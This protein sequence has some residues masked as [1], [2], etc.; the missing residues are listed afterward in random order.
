MSMAGGWRRDINVF[1]ANYR[2]DQT[3]SEIMAS[4]PWCN[5]YRDGPAFRGALKQLVG[6]GD[7]KRRTLSKAERIAR[8]ANYVYEAAR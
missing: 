8:H 4:M 5:E 2:G 6:R 3:A 7:I 1:L